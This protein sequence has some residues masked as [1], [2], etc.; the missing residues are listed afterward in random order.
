MQTVTT[1]IPEFYTH[2]EKLM[3]SFKKK[4]FG[5]VTSNISV[6]G[7]ISVLLAAL[8]MQYQSVIESLSGAMGKDYANFD[9]M[10]TLMDAV[11]NESMQKMKDAC[12]E[13]WKDIMEL[14]VLF[15][16][17]DDIQMME[18]YTTG[19]GYYGV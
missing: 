13:T 2:L 17:H 3:N 15:D 8:Y 4:G 16:R 12:P 5:T 10:V 7:A 6:Y 9:E 11:T 19:S 1:V 14:F 18:F